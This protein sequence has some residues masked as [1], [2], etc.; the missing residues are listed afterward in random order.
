MFLLGLA[1]NIKSLFGCNIIV[2]RMKFNHIIS[3]KCEEIVWY[4]TVH[5]NMK[6]GLIIA[7]I[8]PS[9]GD[10]NPEEKVP[11]SPHFTGNSCFS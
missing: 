11:G 3:S 9:K 8:P 1:F 10:E 4:L 2:T 5:F 7:K 6:Q